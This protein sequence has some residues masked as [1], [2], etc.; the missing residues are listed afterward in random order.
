MLVTPTDAMAR[1]Y[2][3]KEQREK[4]RALK[5][6]KF[7]L[8]PRN[9][10][11]NIWRTLAFCNGISGYGYVHKA[12]M[13]ALDQKARHTATVLNDHDLQKKAHCW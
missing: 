11:K 6:M 9:Q 2:C 5:D 13:L 8:K 3:Q 4:C 12:S 10:L 1:E 7:L